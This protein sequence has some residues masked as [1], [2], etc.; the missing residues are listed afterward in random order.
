MS[1]LG[2]NLYLPPPNAI[3]TPITLSVRADRHPQ[4]M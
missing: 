3:P 2:K 1:L 4:N